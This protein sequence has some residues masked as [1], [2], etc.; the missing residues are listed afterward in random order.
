[1]STFFLFPWSTLDCRL[2]NNSLASALGGACA[3]GTKTMALIQTCQIQAIM[4]VQKRLFFSAQ[5]SNWNLATCWHVELSMLGPP[6]F[7]QHSYE[8]RLQLFYQVLSFE[9]NPW[10]GLGRILRCLRNHRK[11]LMSNRQT[12]N[13]LLPRKQE[14]ELIDQI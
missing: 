8:Q 5:L 1:M 14:C 2:Y 3:M 12:C 9:N 13:N 7:N 11:T 6:P 10:A 4:T